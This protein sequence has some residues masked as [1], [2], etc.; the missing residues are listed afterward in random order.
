MYSGKARR[1]LQN[2][3]AYKRKNGRQGAGPSNASDVLCP[4][5]VALALMP[6]PDTHLFH[7][8][9]CSTDELD[10]AG[11]GVWDLE[12]PYALLSISKWGVAESEK[13]VEVMHGRRLR[14]QREH[15]KQ[16]DQ[17]YGHVP[18]VLKMEIYGDM[19]AALRRW[20][21]A[22]R[23]VEGGISESSEGGL[24]AFRMAQH[25]LQW[26]ARTVYMLYD[27]YIHFDRHRIVAAT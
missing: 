25:Y 9:L 14:M 13:L 23:V 2:R 6:L 27:K 24:Q 18:S 1:S 16:R 15:E 10:E 21:A 20:E 7:E 12:P 11:L 17:L 4:S 19:V 8:A 26:Q 5:L 3:V 22:E